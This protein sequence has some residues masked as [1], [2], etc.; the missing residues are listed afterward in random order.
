MR[1]FLQNET[2]ECPRLVATLEN[3]SSFATVNLDVLGHVWK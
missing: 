1:G 3:G 2:Q